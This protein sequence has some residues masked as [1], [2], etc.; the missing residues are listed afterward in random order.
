MHRSSYD[1][2]GLQ[3][4]AIGCSDPAPDPAPAPDLASRLG[5]RTSKQILPQRFGKF[6]RHE[7]PTHEPCRVR[8]DVPRDLG[9]RCVLLQHCV[10]RSVLHGYR[11]MHQF[12]QLSGLSSLLP[13][14]SGRHKR[15]NP[16]PPHKRPNPMHASKL[17]RVR[18]CSVRRLCCP[19]RHSSVGECGRSQSGWHVFGILLATESLVQRRLGRHDEQSMQPVSTSAWMQPSVFR[20]ER[21][22]LSMHSLT[23]T[24]NH[25]RAYVQP[26]HQGANPGWPDV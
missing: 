11:T 9:L 1:I 7:S 19:G 12:D 14:S 22:H 5:A 16:A 6:G 4:L 25:L 20:H 13:A 21:R 23:C 26:Y 18:W 24:A 15:P 17:D 2:W 3:H 10:L 8:D